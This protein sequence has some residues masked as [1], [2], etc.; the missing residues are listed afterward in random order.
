MIGLNIYN[1][2]DSLW[3]LLLSILL[4]LT[5]KIILNDKYTLNIKEII[6][7]SIII[8]LLIVNI[9]NIVIF[10]ISNLGIV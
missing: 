7:N 2:I 8:N 6:I 10:I 3:Y 9:N 4:G 5:S 1:N